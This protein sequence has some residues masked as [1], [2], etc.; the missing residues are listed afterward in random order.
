[1]P[2]KVAA[3][4]LAS[5]NSPMGPLTSRGAPE[6]SSPRASSAAVLLARPV[7]RSVPFSRAK[8]YIRFPSPD[9]LNRVRSLLWADSNLSP[10]LF[11]GDRAS[12]RL[13]LITVLSVVS[14]F[15][16]SCAV[17]VTTLAPVTTVFSLDVRSTVVP[18]ARSIVMLLFG[19]NSVDGS[20]GSTCLGLTMGPSAPDN[21]VS[22]CSEP[23][24]AGSLI[25]D[26]PGFSSSGSAACAP[27]VST[28]ESGLDR[29]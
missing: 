4:A 25:F 29:A 28:S 22:I 3:A 8:L 24:T 9:L 19:S 20:E 26:S 10:N 2:S 27:A 6:S 14:A 7:A 15:T 5:P 17:R 13:C 18:D 12:R 21:S 11:S 23:A 16:T 1:M